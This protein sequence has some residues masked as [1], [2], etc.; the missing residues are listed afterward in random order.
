ME[1]KIWQTTVANISLITS[2]YRTHTEL[3]MAA[4]WYGDL[5]SC[6]FKLYLIFLF[7]AQQYKAVE[8]IG[9]QI[10]LDS[11]LKHSCNVSNKEWQRK[12]QV[13]RNLLEKQIGKKKE[14]GRVDEKKENM[15]LVLRKWSWNRWMTLHVIHSN[16]PHKIQHLHPTISFLN[17]SVVKEQTTLRRSLYIFQLLYLSWHSGSAS[18]IILKI[19]PWITAP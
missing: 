15:S 3:K 16:D 9:A 19:L 6:C 2:A 12:T 4:W 10:L 7:S 18:A 1:K 13:S 14:G 17:L 11:L 8:R 5:C